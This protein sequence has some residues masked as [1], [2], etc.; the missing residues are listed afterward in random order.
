MGVPASGQS[1]SS[2]QS[3]P[4]SS[5][6]DKAAEL[7]KIHPPNVTV[8]N[9]KAVEVLNNQ[10]SQP[11]QKQSTHTSMPAKFMGTLLRPVVAF[12]KLFSSSKSEPK[13]EV[14][15]NQARVKVPRRQMSAEDKAA[16]KQ[17]Q[18]MDKE[19]MFVS[20]MRGGN[21]DL[22]SVLICTHRNNSETR[23]LLAD[24]GDKVMEIQDPEIRKTALKNVLE[25]GLDYAVRGDSIPVSANERVKIR[26]DLE[27]IVKLGASS[28]S[29][30]LNNLAASVKQ[31]LPLLAPKVE[32]KAI[33]DRL[34]GGVTKP[35]LMRSAY[36]ELRKVKHIV[37]EKADL[38]AELEKAK[39]KEEPNQN[40]IAKLTKAI[41]DLDRE[42]PTVEADMSAL[43]AGIEKMETSKKVPKFSFADTSATQFSDMLCKVADESF[44]RVSSSE[45]DNLAC[46]KSVKRHQEAPNLSDHIQVFNNMTNLAI[47]EILLASN[48]RKAVEKVIDAAHV[49]MQNN[50]FFVA[51]ALL[52]AVNDTNVYRLP[53]MK[54]GLSNRTKTK[55]A[56]MEDV[57]SK[58]SSYSKALT[59][60]T[61]AALSK[62]K[63][64][65]P[66]IAPFMTMMTMTMEGNS[67]AVE[68][69]A[70]PAVNLRKNQL[71]EDIKDQISLHL[72]SQDFHANSKP[73]NLGLLV[74]LETIG[75]IDKIAEKFKARSLE[76]KPLG[77][78]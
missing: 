45:L 68:V 28:D 57:F 7:N 40:E 2:F 59:E 37:G 36:E 78:G 23:N 38:K 53:F 22:T 34:A 21:K 29:P 33:L 19:A 74:A 16:R 5:P 64:A 77:R 10:Q 18:S 31:N 17:M 62:N 50:N 14:V 65:N 76:L 3:N 43:Q 6:D 48:P 41:A 8:A 27:V 63:P 73:S 51:G 13:A 56:V 20:I 49:A 26:G 25:F 75:R 47:N 35:E 42:Y 46:S 61:N 54:D 55:K 58:A 52:A 44:S 72:E 70:S 67:D 32:P 12:R 24:L 39:G 69:N 30:E 9:N 15:G 11:A 1:Q 66:Y 4:L 71:I 60:R